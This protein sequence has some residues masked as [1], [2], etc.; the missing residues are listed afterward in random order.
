METMV[1]NSA[2]GVFTKRN[3]LR[4]DPQILTPNSVAKYTC[5]ENLKQNTTGYSTCGDDGVLS[6]ATQVNNVDL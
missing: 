2:P 4:R 1:E 5:N 3:F 6:T